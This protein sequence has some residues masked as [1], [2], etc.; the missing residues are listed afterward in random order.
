MPLDELLAYARRISKFTVP[1]T[2]RPPLPGEAK[3]GLQTTPTAD[4]K[5]ENGVPSPA[6]GATPTATQTGQEGTQ[7]SDAAKKEE[8][9]G[10]SSLTD[11]QRAW[12]D[13]ASQIPFVPWPSEDTIRKGALAG[14][15]HMLEQGKDPTTFVPE[16]AAGSEHEA[17]QEDESQRMDTGDTQHVQGVPGA[18]A[19]PPPQEQGSGV[20]GGLEL[21][22]PDD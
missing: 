6:V 7:S 2:Y 4:A 16:P 3:E 18:I 15:Q 11:E 12:L 17:G 1:P 10:V 21:Y 14:I 9:V 19:R 5:M 13:S 8:G 20:F 22:N